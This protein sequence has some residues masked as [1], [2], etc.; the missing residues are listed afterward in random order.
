MKNFQLLLRLL[1]PKTRLLP[2]KTRMKLGLYGFIVFGLAFW[3]LNKLVGIFYTSV[4]SIQKV[5]VLAHSSFLSP[6][7]YFISFCLLIFCIYLIGM[8]VEKRET[9]LSILLGKIPFINKIWKFFKK[10]REIIHH[11]NEFRVVEI[12]GYP[13][14]GGLPLA[15]ITGKI[16]RIENGER[17]FFPH[18]SV[19]NPPS[20]VGQP[21]LF[22]REKLKL[23]LMSPEEFF[24]IMFSFGTSGPE[25]RTIHPNQEILDEYYRE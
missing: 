5:L 17:K 22:E 2:L 1:P 16:C 21:F 13:C 23:V 14:L 9:K 10:G 15:L 8:L 7:G 4:S 11:L 20:P 19:S 24:E 25:E 12:Q 3:A 6:W 18:I